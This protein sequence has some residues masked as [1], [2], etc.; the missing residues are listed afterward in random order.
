MN[1]STETI[2]R[3]LAA[4]RNYT[5]MAVGFITGI[6]L[7]SAAQQKSFTDALTEIF[8]GLTQIV[9]GASSIWQILIV[10][11]P[12][13]GIAMAK[14]ASNSAKVTSQVASVKAAV[15][16]PNTPISPEVKQDIIATAKAV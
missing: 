16:D 2:G 6:G 1:I 13:I 12:A 3:L 10:A 8:N 11:F 7:M 14:F 4:G 9:H 5:S 15:A